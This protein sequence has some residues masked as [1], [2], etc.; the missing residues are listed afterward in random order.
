MNTRSVISIHELDSL[1][2]LQSLLQQGIAIRIRVFGISMQPLLKGG[3]L[4]EIVPLCGTCFQLGDILFLCNRQGNPLIHRLIWWSFQY[5]MLHL[6]TKGDACA[7][8]D[9][10]VPTDR[11]LGRV[12]QIIPDGEPPVSLD[13]PLLR[14][15][16]Y[17]IVGRTLFIHTLSK[18]RL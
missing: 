8:F 5:G 7:G 13:A 4:V 1:A 18:L 12:R 3:E 10:F 9:S 16:S 11:V 15:R 17:L 14:L 2:L 6:L